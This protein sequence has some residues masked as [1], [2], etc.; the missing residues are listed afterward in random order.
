MR[1]KIEERK[2]Y[3]YRRWTLSA[4]SALCEIMNGLDDAYDIDLCY[5]DK[6]I[7]ILYFGWNN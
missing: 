4:I 2:I 5:R 1:D 3:A 7:Q 6:T